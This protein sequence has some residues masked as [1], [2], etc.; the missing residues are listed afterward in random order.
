MNDIFLPILPL[1]L[2]NVKTSNIQ[3]LTQLSRSVKH[4]KKVYICLGARSGEEKEEIFSSN[5]AA[6]ARV[7]AGYIVMKAKDILPN[8][9][10]EQQ[11]FALTCIFMN[12]LFK[13]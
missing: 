5:V 11:L 2:T 6:I 1:A 10:Q 13:C 4:K 8:M 7:A 3:F 9:L 12:I